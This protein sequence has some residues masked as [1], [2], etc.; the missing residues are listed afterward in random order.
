MEVLE[1]DAGEGDTDTVQGKDKEM[2]YRLK[3]YYRT[4]L[5]DK[6]TSYMQ[7]IFD[8][9]K[10]TGRQLQVCQVFEFETEPPLS[11]E[12]KAKL[13]ALKEDWTDEVELEEVKGE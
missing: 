4:P 1:S 11:D 8:D 2:R 3:V 5:M 6:I 12:V 13:V 7:D 10:H 9:W